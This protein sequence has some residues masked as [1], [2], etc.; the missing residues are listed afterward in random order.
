[1][2]AAA[3]NEWV[4]ATEGAPCFQPSGKSGASTLG[5]LP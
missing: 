3:P 2:A 4:K 1:M 5:A